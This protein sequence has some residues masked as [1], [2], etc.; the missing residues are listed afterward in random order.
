VMGS[1]AV[2]D[3]SGTTVARKVDGALC[4]DVAQALAFATALAIDP[5]ARP[6]PDGGSTQDA[7]DDTSGAPAQ[8]PRPD[9]ASPA[10]SP[11]HG[12]ARPT[13]PAQGAS[14]RRP[15]EAGRDRGSFDIALGPSLAS[16]IAPR[17]SLGAAASLGWEARPGALVAWLGLEITALRALSTPVGTASSSFD[18]VHGRPTLCL[19]ALAL[20]TEFRIM[21]CLAAEL[22]VVI[23][24][25]SN[26]AA[27]STETR[28]WGAAEVGARARLELGRAWFVQADAS[29]VLPLTRYDFVFED[30]NT[31]IYTVPSLAAAAGA[32]LGW[33]L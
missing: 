28:F 17:I 18:F 2:K 1:L 15:V 4:A 32:K 5:D 29:L 16:G 30:P 10:P 14:D 12:S 21:P 31:P 8:G 11:E 13:S 24:R 6:L 33:F 3:E 9:E 20:S 19:F 25:G 22:G 26:I 23:G 7:A 27:A